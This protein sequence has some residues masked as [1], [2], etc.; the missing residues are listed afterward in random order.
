MN[1]KLLSHKSIA[2]VALLLCVLALSASCTTPVEESVEEA[3]TA[4]A[5]SETDTGEAEAEPTAESAD[6]LPPYL[7]PT[8]DTEARIDDLLSRMTLDE[9]IGQMTLVEKGS[10]PPRDVTR[11]HIGGVL[12][13]G[14]GGPDGDNSPAGWHE[15]V[16]E[17]QAA[18]LETELQIPLIYGVDSVHGHS[19]VTGATIFPHNI[20]LGATRN[21]DL[22]AEIAHATALETLATG[23][24]WN[25]APVAAVPRDIRWGRTYE[26]FGETSDLVTQ[27]AAA[28]LRGFQMVDGVTD[29]AHPNTLLGT[30]K[31]F[32]GDGGTAWGSSTTGDYL[33]DQGDTQVDEAILRD[34]HLSPYPVLIENG[35]LSI[36]ASF[37]SW[38]GLKMHAHEY[39]LNDVL[40]GELG[41]TGFVVSD[42]EAIDQI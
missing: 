35:A 3:S 34:V 40:K 5:V 31:H 14:G 42:W 10:I 30:P 29:L 2:V 12:S 8:L 11:Y 23:I 38:N 24:H 27:M 36:M 33:I 17:Y 4:P 21:P 25:Y 13:G 15:M 20:G 16:G 1:K 22:V 41:F 9:K 37:S 26:G 19:N 39:L 7:D 32:V 28:Q 6:S 18:T